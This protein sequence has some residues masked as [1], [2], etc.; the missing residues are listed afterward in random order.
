[1]SKKNE[2]LGSIDDEIKEYDKSLERANKF[3]KII[4]TIQMNKEAAEAKFNMIYAMPEDIIEELYPRLSLQQSRTNEYLTGPLGLIP[5]IN[6]KQFTTDLNAINSTTSFTEVILTIVNSES[7]EKTKPDWINDVSSV[8]EEHVKNVSHRENIPQRLIKLFPNLDDLFLIA[9]ESIDRCKAGNLKIST[10]AMDLRAV[11]NQ[12]WGNLVHIARKNYS[13]NAVTSLEFKKEYDR[14]LVAEILTNSE[15]Q[16]KK[17]VESLH[18]AYS[19]FSQL[20]ESN[21][22]KNLIGKDLERLISIYNQWL[23]VINDI[24]EMVCN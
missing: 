3:T 12:I 6:E 2:I 22:G 24:T 14:N 23:L 10:G 8:I 15:T 7:N 17:L 5:D 4:S 9:I 20:S 21:F 18:L 1:M 13:G 19:L 11:L 16:R